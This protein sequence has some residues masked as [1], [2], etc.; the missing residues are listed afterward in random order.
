METWDETFFFKIPCL[1]GFQL[2]EN[3]A[4]RYLQERGLDWNRVLA[5]CRS[6]ENPR[7]EDIAD[8][9]DKVQEEASSYLYC[10]LC[11]KSVFHVSYNLLFPSFSEMIYEGFDLDRFFMLLLLW[12]LFQDLHRTGCTGFSGAKQAVLK[13]VL[14]A[15]AKWNPQVGY[16]QGFNMIGAMLLQMT[17]GNEPLTLKIFVFLI[18]GVLPQGLYIYIHFEYF[19]SVFLR[20]VF[21][22]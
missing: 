4:D 5:K 11:D 21:M 8:Q 18:E 15:Y 12:L 16:C 13:R 9:I 6:L 14:V 7:D 17:Q 22:K 10:V 1:F 3:L 20:T 2:W 19:F